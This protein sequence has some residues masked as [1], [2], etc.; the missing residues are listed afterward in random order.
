VSKPTS[1]SVLV[2]HLLTRSEIKFGLGNVVI[3]SELPNFLESLY[4]TIVTYYASEIAVKLSLLYQYRRVF[5]IPTPRRILWWLAAYLYFFSIL[6][7][8]M[9]IFTCW[10]VAKYWDDTIQGGCMERSYL[11]Y[12][13]AAVN[14]VNDW[15]FWTFPLPLLRKLKLP[16]GQKV[17]LIGVFACGFLSVICPRSLDAIESRIC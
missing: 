9:A 13:L 10:P 1:P 2:S 5:P 7:M 15:I 14:I 8:A 17:V 3:I 16:M 6:T 11:H 4:F 12:S